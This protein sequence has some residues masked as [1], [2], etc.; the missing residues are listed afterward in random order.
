MKGTSYPFNSPV[1][2]S[3]P[4]PCV[5]VCHHIST[6]LYNLFYQRQFNL[7]PVTSS[8]WRHTN[9][10]RNPSM[11][12]QYFIDIGLVT[13]FFFGIA[14]TQYLL[15]GT[16]NGRYIRKSLIFASRVFFFSEYHN[17]Y[18]GS[19]L[20]VWQYLYLTRCESYMLES[21][22]I[23]YM[24]KSFQI[25]NNY[26]VSLNGENLYNTIHFLKQ[27]PECQP[28]NVGYFT[29]NNLSHAIFI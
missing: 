29:V 9:I 27:T 1:S 16:G 13:I 25:L 4:L 15:G 21:I 17:R 7:A 28:I 11:L 23:W 5:S 12:N 24:K 10:T 19:I 8:S 2:S 18:A 22:R 14:G 3:L 20:N 26:W 6:R